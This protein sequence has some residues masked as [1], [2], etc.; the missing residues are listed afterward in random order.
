MIKLI[1]YN[2]DEI[3]S[4]TTDAFESPEDIVVL[5][6]NKL[7]PHINVGL[8]T[9]FILNA[10]EQNDTKYAVYADYQRIQY[11]RKLTILDSTG[12]V[13]INK[14]QL[15]DT[16]SY[17]DNNYGVDRGSIRLHWLAP[18]KLDNLGITAV[19]STET[20]IPMY[21]GHGSL[22]LGRAI[23]HGAGVGTLT[24]GLLPVNWLSLVEVK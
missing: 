23:N 1:G 12:L 20:N 18:T 15:Q 19:E 14:S 9:L 3:E 16:W 4:A 2:I 21:V 7:L 8:L 11:N 13:V 5:I 22:L 10:V 24:G 6:S 17:N